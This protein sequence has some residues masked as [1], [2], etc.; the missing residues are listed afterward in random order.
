VSA[1]SSGWSFPWCATVGGAH[2]PVV[3]VSCFLW[4][5]CVAER[6][7]PSRSPR[8]V[9]HPPHSRAMADYQ[10][11]GEADRAFLQGAN[12]GGIG[13]GATQ[14]SLRHVT[15]G[16]PRGGRG[17][18]PPTRQQR[19][20]QPAKLAEDSSIQNAKS[21]YY[22]GEYKP[23]PPP[24]SAAAEAAPSRNSAGSATRGGRGAARSASRGGRGASRRTGPSAARR[25]VAST[26]VLLFFP[27]SVLARVFS[28]FCSVLAR[29]LT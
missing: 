3:C 7:P 24:S 13:R 22:S 28:L 8:N 29:V 27:F 20:I 17:R 23:P 21:M 14:R 16:R 25:R 9:L 19:R 12:V 6:Y 5:V 11:P 10:Q 15:A 2:L 18:R 26:L 4:L 1:C